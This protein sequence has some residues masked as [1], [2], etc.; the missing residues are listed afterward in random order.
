MNE[1][2]QADLCR[3]RYDSLDRRLTA[4]EQA[5]C[6]PA[7]PAPSDGASASSGGT[8]L[9]P[10]TAT[11]DGSSAVPTRPKS[12]D[13][14]TVSSDPSAAI[15]AD[16]CTVLPPAEIADHATELGW[17][18][19]SE[20]WKDPNYKCYRVFPSGM[21]KSPT[22]VFPT[23]LSRADCEATGHT[24]LPNRRVPKPKP[25]AASA[26][27]EFERRW[28]AGDWAGDTKG[29]AFNAFVAA[30]EKAAVEA[31][32]K[33]DYQQG[34][35]DGQHVAENKHRELEKALNWAASLAPKPDAG[36]A[37]G[38]T[39]YAAVNCCGY[40]YSGY[41]RPGS[42]AEAAWFDSADT[43]A[44][45]AGTDGRVVTRHV[46]VEGRAEGVKCLFCG[47]EAGS[48]GKPPAWY[49]RDRECMG[50]AIDRFVPAP[51][52][53]PRRAPEVVAREVW[54]TMPAG[55]VND[56]IEFGAAAIK[57]DRSE[58]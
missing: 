19:E 6:S 26:W 25:A 18:V 23:S 39:Q 13:A 8:T 10:S 17:T 57:A 47:G 36:R 52:P 46:P 35:A 7:S 44:K 28:L 40:Y 9:N 4:L 2:D 30:R 58:G 56:Y 50:H 37:E 3:M 42:E 12:A 43:P 5:A 54:D 14:A 33:L 48:M 51:A 49:C 34:F 32:G 45:W 24:L 31:R 55:R 1:K 20:V 29:D 41:N 21:V 38:R 11:G 53:K 16:D 15:R 27:E 22:R